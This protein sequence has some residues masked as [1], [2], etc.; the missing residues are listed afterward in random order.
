MTNPARRLRRRR[1]P[2]M[3]GRGGNAADRGRGPGHVSG[4]KATRRP[5][6][7]V[8]STNRAANRAARASRKAGR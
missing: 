5:K 3:G 2:I 7:T 6:A 1:W 4:A 8:K